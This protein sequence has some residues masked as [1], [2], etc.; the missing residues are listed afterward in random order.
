M[1]TPAVS[2]LNVKVVMNVQKVI[3][4]TTYGLHSERESSSR[5][6]DINE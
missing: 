4:L 6:D 1:S 3:N 2:D 5:R